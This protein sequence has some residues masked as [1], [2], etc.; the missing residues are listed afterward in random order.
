MRTFSSLKDLP[1]YHKESGKELGRVIDLCFDE[2]GI[3]NG[4]MMDPKGFLKKHILIPLSEIASFGLDGVMVS[5]E[6]IDGQTNDKLKKT[7]FLQ[8]GH[9][10]V[11]GK[12]LVT[13]EGEKLGLVEDVYF[14]EE[15]GTIVG[16]E[17]TDGFFADMAEGRKI[18][19]TVN[20]LTIGE[21]II[22]VDLDQSNSYM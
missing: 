21:N 7:H 19:K 3:V 12:P 22:I 15:L 8:S 16:Y 5:H 6:P 2:N 11:I 17:V 4:L 13:T 20:P 14:K 10:R 18:Y 9:D 1:I